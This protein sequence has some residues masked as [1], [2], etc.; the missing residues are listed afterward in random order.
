MRAVQVQSLE[1][2]EG[3]AV[4]DV[5][6]PEAGDGALIEGH[7]AGISFPDLLLSRG[8]YQIKPDPPFTLG[9]EAAGVVREA[10]ADSDLQPGDRVVG[11]VMGAF[12]ELATAPA[13]M[14]FPL[15]E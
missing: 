10:P 7:A 13:H 4:A 5:P 2:P 6:E 11:I 12:A 8:L 1:G 14:I 15:P 9:T 3:L